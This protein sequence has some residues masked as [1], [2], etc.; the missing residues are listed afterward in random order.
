MSLELNSA[1]IYDEGGK[2]NFPPKEGER[3]RRYGCGISRKELKEIIAK[4]ILPTTVIPVR[5][6]ENVI[7]K[8]EG[9]EH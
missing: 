1:N 2:L 9:L 6:E 5:G 7:D 4:G 8:N 3:A